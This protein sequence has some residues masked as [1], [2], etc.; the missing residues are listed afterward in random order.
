M[1][2]HPKIGTGYARMSNK[3]TNYLASIPDV[4]VVCYTFDY[5][6]EYEIKDRYVDSRIK[7]YDSK[8]ISSQHDAFGLE[9]I[10]SVL[11]IEKPDVLF[12]YN[13]TVIASKI[14]ESIPLQYIPPV[15]YL[16]LDI[17]YPWQSAGLYDFIKRSEFDHIFVFLECWKTHLVSDIGFSESKVSVLPQAIDFENIKYISNDEAKGNLGL[18]PTDYLIVNM[19]RNSWRKGWNITISAFLQFLKQ[20]NM[21]TAIKLFC[22]CALNHPCGYDIKMLIIDECTRLNIDIERVMTQHIIATNS[23]MNKDDSY[24]NMIYSAGD[25]GLNTCTGEGFGLTTLEHLSHNKPQ[26]VSGV[27]ALKET[28][29]DY[30][31]V[32]EPELMIPYPPYEALVGGH[33]A[34]I[35]YKK[36]AD[37]INFHYENRNIKID[38]LDNLKTKYSLENVYKVLDRFFTNGAISASE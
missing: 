30:A 38:A 8:Q 24:I 5:S 28:I 25:L 11:S 17:L 2:A 34:Y 23:F 10:G 12:I 37:K 16:Y 29:G 31:T 32:I 4:E 9:C 7:I 13:N 36:V 1:S 27:P 33:V 26:I 15:K 20:R 6:Q 18:K 14:L 3:I 19:N 22:G 35:D 21:D